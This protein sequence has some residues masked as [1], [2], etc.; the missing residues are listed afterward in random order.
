MN[1]NVKKLLMSPDI[2]KMFRYRVAIA[3]RCAGLRY[4]PE[5]AVFTGWVQWSAMYNEWYLTI[6]GITYTSLR[7]ATNIEPIY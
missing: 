3:H 1:S 2:Q 5:D 7:N 6:D 4:E